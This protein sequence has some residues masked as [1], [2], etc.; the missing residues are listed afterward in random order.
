[1]TINVLGNDSAANGGTLTITAVGKP[2]F[3]TAT[4][5]GQTATYT[6]NATFVVN[7]SFSYFVSDGKGGTANA[8]VR[9]T[10]S[11]TGQPS[12]GALYLPL[13]YR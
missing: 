1:M 8:A 9:I 6:P 10:I 4:T 2:Q 3:G 12:S 5:D 11:A 7:D 13:V